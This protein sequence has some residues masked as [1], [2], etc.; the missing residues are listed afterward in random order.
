MGPDV[1]RLLCNLARHKDVRCDV[2]HESPI[3]GVRIKCD[4][5]AD[6]NMCWS[7]YQAHKSS[8]EHNTSHAVVAH[9]S[10]V[11]REFNPRRDI[12]YDNQEYLGQGSFG[13]VQ[14]VFYEGKPLALKTI[15]ITGA[16]TDQVHFKSFQNEVFAYSEIHSNQIIKF[17]GYAVETTDSSTNLFLLTEFMEKGSLRDIITNNVV[18]PL[19]LK[20]HWAISI[21]KGR[22]NLHLGSVQAKLF[23]ND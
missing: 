13:C 21:I 14:K 20:F 2:C 19:H 15:R 17:Y 3:Q 1:L 8:K 23:K 22:C 18:V 16:V 12:T 9:L 7:C 6:Y 5:C 4:D 10:P 11:H